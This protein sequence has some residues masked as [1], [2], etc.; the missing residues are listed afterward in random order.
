MIHVSARR[1]RLSKK[2]KY[3]YLKKHISKYYVK[4][5]I[6]VRIDGI[7]EVSNNLIIDLRFEL[8]EYNSIL[9]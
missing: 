2:Y 1:I 4:L 5:L 3:M 8:L 7:F 6:L 9:W